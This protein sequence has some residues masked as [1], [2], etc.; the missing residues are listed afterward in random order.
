M[1]N[2]WVNRLFS[3]LNFFKITTLYHGVYNIRRSKTHA[4]SSKRNY[5]KTIIVQKKN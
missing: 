2:M 4:N 1:V 5:T 3:F